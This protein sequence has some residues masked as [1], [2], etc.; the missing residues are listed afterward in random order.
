M[1]ASE[2]TPEHNN[3]DKRVANLTISACPQRPLA[4]KRPSHDEIELALESLCGC[5]ASGSET[6]ALQF[7]ELELRKDKRDKQEK[8]RGKKP[9]A[10]SFGAETVLWKLQTR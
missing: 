3:E 2:R 4:G 9:L 1:R 8:E 6:A 10:S 7:A 5:L